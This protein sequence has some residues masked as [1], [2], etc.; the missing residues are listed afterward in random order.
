MADEPGDGFPTSLRV[1]L[2]AWYGPAG[3]TDQ[4]SESALPL[5]LAEWHR[6]AAERRRPIAVQNEVVLDDAPKPWFGK[7]P[8]YIENQAAWLWG[9]DPGDADGEVFERCNDAAG[10]WSGT[11][12]RLREFLL[13]VAVFEAVMGAD[14]CVSISSV[15]GTVLGSVTSSLR[16]V[17]VKPWRWPGPEHQLWYRDDVVAFTC[18]NAF[19]ND[20][21]VFVG[22]R[23]ENALAFLDRLELRVDYDSRETSPCS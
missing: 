1:F 4:V 22:A 20:Y 17:P 3:V 23:S 13:H 8:V 10:E 12:E 16:R 6:Q 15:T 18:A 11:G 19:P 21:A 2:D 14:A 9:V 7:R 5:P